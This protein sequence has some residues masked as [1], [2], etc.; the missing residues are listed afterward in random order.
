MRAQ[1]KNDLI[2]AIM[3]YIQHSDLEDVR[4]RLTMVLGE[5]EVTKA[6]RELAVWEGDKNDQM[7]KRFLAAKI[8][9]G[10][11][12]RTIDHYRREINRMHERIGKTY[13]EV[14]ADDIRLYLAVRV[15]KDKVSKVTAKN[16]KLANSTFY[17]WLQK[18]EILLRNPMSKVGTIKAVKRKQKAFSQMEVEKIRSACR[19]NREKAIIEVLLSTWCRVS[20]LVNIKIS[21]IDDNQ[22]KVLGKGEKERIVYLNAKA[23]LAISQYLCERND[24]NGFLFPRAKYTSLASAYTN[25]ATIK[26]YKSCKW[27]MNP[28]L[29]N[30]DGHT[31]KASMEEIVR[32]MGKR[33]GVKKTHPHRFRR[34]GAT[35]ALRAGMPLLTVSKL[36]GHES[37][38]TTQMYLDISDKELEQTHEKYVF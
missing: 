4:M 28:E 35:A 14:T 12:P 6:S 30:E 5:Y 18:E 2:N 13:D 15:H 7:I 31:D 27:Y 21:D 37:V 34:T 20:E 9:Q 38:A 24:T 22:V 25:K 3:P 23:M 33:A 17:T 10:C 1:L 11:T 29:V 26:D 19:S 32:N 16:E 8:A 36:L